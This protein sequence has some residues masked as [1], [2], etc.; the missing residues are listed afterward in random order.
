[1][2]EEEPATRTKRFLRAI[3]PKYFARTSAQPFRTIIRKC[4]LVS[5]SMTGPLLINLVERCEDGY[6]YVAAF[7]DSDENF[8]LY[9]RFGYL[10]SRLLLRKQDKL[11]KLEAEL[12]EFDEEDANGTLQQRR[13]LMSRD[14]DEAADRREPEGT[15]TRTMILDDIEE[16]LAKYGQTRSN[17]ILRQ[18]SND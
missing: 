18:F 13:L 14:C 12:D 4:E 9:R 17:L 10:H 11:R 3:I 16:N 8:M 15:R 6:P 5:F 7:L 1:M 2:H